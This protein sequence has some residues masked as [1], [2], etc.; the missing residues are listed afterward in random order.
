MTRF[1]YEINE[2]FQNF[3]D[4]AFLEPLI[5]RSGNLVLKILLE[6]SCSRYHVREIVYEKSCSK[7]PV[8]H[9]LF[10]KSCTK[11]PVRIIPFQKSRTKY[12]V[13]KLP[14]DCRIKNA[15]R[16]ILYEKSCA[17]KSY[18]QPANCRKLNCD[19]LKYSARRQHYLAYRTFLCLLRP[20]AD[21]GH[22]STGYKLRIKDIL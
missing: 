5:A 1:F 7:I 10:E 2:S 22:Q 6:K 4:L 9:F 11:N 8:R 13:R 18:R 14:L 3:C 17:K 12:L 19:D 15:V 21:L 16:E 20:I